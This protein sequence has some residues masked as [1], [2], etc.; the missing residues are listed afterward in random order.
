QPGEV[1]VNVQPAKAEVRFRDAAG[2]YQLVHDTVRAR[3]HEA[4]LKA[5]MPPRPKPDRVLGD[6]GRADPPSP[7][8]KGLSQSVPE[9]NSVPTPVPREM[10]AAPRSSS[11][12]RGTPPA[13]SAGSA[14][15]A[16][17]DLFPSER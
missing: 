11:A 17:A 5:P 16:A 10:P 6:E 7:S 1:D 9:V 13:A 2:L 3:L 15:A 8:G 14:P 12:I 4:D